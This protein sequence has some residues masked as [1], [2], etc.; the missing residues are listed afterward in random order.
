V[1][2]GAVQELTK[3]LAGATRQKVEVDQVKPRPKWLGKAV[4]AGGGIVARL[5]QPPAWKHGR[6]WPSVRLC[7]VAPGAQYAALPSRRVDTLRERNGIN[8]R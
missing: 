2:T 3:E 7:S 6:L 5:M 8:S 1:P 4:M